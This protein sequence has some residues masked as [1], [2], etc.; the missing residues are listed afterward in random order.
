MV[1]NKNEAEEEECFDGKSFVSNTKLGKIM[2]DFQH[3][4]FYKKR[5]VKKMKNKILAGIIL[6]LTQNN[7]MEDKIIYEKIVH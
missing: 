1:W 7:L 4:D 5:W 6:R 2:K 3:P